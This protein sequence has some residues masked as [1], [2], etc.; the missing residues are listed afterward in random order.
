VG[1]SG[2]VVVSLTL[3]GFE[4][5]EGFEEENTSIKTENTTL[6][7]EIVLLREQVGGK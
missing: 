1:N 4:T 6:Q 3:L 5:L 7:D 2:L